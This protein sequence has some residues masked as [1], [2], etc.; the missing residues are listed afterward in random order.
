[1]RSHGCQ[2]RLTTT[3]THKAQAAVTDFC[4]Q[5]ARH[6]CQERYRASSRAGRAAAHDEAGA[7]CTRHDT[8]RLV[9]G[10]R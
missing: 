8:W 1:M 3:A 4:F 2:Q 7:L 5:N 6:P 9:R 10:Y